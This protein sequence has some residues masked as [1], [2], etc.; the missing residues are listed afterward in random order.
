MV[1]IP[2]GSTCQLNSNRSQIDRFSTSHLNLLPLIPMI[3]ISSTLVWQLVI[4]IP[5][6][7]AQKSVNFEHSITDEE[8]VV[9]YCATISQHYYH[10]RT[11]N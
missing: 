7:K 6:A 4:E 1:E 11:I 2:Q 8:L 10:T 5:Q 3:Q 9:K